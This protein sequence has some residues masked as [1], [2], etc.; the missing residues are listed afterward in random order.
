MLTTGANNPENRNAIWS[1]LASP[2][3]TSW[4]FVAFVEQMTEYVSRFTDI[5][6]N[7]AA[8]QIP[9]IQVD[10]QNDDQSFF[11]READR[12]QS[13]HQLA[14]QQSSLVLEPATT[15]G[16]Y[17]LYEE[18]SRVVLR[19]FSVNS[20]SAESDLTRLTEDELNQRLGEDQYKV[21]TNIDELKDDIS[22]A[23]VGQEVFPMLLMLVVV[24]FAGE[25]LVANRFYGGHEKVGAS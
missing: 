15:L 12:R 22:A 24:A 17:D 14:A 25:H 13:R 7:F 20:P 23:D 2:L 5:E 8:G 1:N 19:G 21:A 6:H 4:V 9:V 3:V 11:L 16:H 18:G 10:P